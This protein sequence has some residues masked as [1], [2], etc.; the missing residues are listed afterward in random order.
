MGETAYP[1]TDPV[2]SMPVEEQSKHASYGSAG[3]DSGGG[4]GRAS[5]DA[6]GCSVSSVLSGSSVAL[7]AV[8]ASTPYCRPRRAR[9][10]RTGRIP[11]LVGAPVRGSAAVVA[12]MSKAPVALMS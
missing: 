8:G 9:E 10:A 2:P 7:P 4:I 12:V 3:G 11:W 6:D 5:E 1:L